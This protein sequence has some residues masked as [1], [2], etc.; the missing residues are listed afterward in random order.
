[1]ADKALSMAHSCILNVLELQN[2]Q[3]KTDG[4]G[5]QLQICLR[6]YLEI[7]APDST[8]LRGAETEPS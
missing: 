2:E 8:Y 4:L 5:E 3:F 1:M 7:W 6:D